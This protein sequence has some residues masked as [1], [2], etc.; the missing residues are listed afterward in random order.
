MQE[1][2][3]KSEDVPLEILRRSLNLVQTKEEAREIEEK[4]AKIIEV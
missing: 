3:V 4:M 2:A 1:D